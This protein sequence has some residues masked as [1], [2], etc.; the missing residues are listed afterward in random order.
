MEKQ[1]TAMHELKDILIS[2]PCKI[3]TG[4]DVE[5]VINAINTL[6]QKEEMQIR[7]AYN[8]GGTDAHFKGSKDYFTENYET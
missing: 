7:K 5:D 1:K 6:L 3:D 2:M 4:L 8:I